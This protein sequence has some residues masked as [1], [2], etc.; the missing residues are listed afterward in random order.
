MAAIL[1]NTRR[2]GAGRAA[3]LKNPRWCPISERNGFSAM[4]PT[5]TACKQA[6]VVK[7]QYFFMFLSSYLGCVSLRKSKIG[8][9]YPKESENK[10]CLSL[11]DRSIQDQSTH[12][13]LRDLGLICQVKK[14]KIRVRIPS[15]LKIP[16]WIFL[17]KRTLAVKTSVT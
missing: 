16:S 14:R 6:N 8:F 11:L 2:G 3:R 15:D 4:E 12:H 1:D 13:D 10:I 5:V 17:K 9:L 7:E